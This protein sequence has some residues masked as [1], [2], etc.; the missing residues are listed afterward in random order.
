MVSTRSDK[1][2]TPD[3]QVLQPRAGAAVVVL[4]GEHDLASKKTLSELLDSLLGTHE[5]VVADL[6]QVLFIDSS[7]LAVFVGAD[8]TARAAGKTFRLQLGAEP[9]VKRILEISRLE[10]H[11][12]CAATRD[13]ALA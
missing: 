5:L 10:D 2:T 11:L 8:R 4:T 9:I 3:L 6:S 7:T 1:M 13:E 12:D